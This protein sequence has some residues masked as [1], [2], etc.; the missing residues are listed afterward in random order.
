MFEKF[1]AYVGRI[2]RVNIKLIIACNIFFLALFHPL[3][4]VSYAGDMFKRAAG[5]VDLSTPDLYANLS[6]LPPDFKEGTVLPTST[7]DLSSVAN[8]EIPFY[9]ISSFQTSDLTLSKCG[10]QRVKVSP[11]HPF[12]RQLAE[13]AKN[14]DYFLPQNRGK[15]ISLR[16][17]AAHYIEGLRASLALSFDMAVPLDAV[18]R[19]SGSGSSNPFRAIRLAHVDFSGTPSKVF[20]E[21]SERWRETIAE[22]IGAEKVN[23]FLER[24]DDATVEMIHLWVPI[25]NEPANN[26]LALA[27]I[28][29]LGEDSVIPY[30][31]VRRNNSTFTALGIK[32]NSSQRW[33]YSTDMKLGD[34]Y[35]FLSRRTP[36]AS[37][38]VPIY[39]NV[40]RQS[41]EFRMLLIRNIP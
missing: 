37:I 29:S 21:F 30:T 12:F 13:N 17:A 2:M 41:I 20:S 3:V 4:S 22:R 16:R 23:H 6:F 25:H 19:I 11:T 31:A 15:E 38:D 5:R 35:V 28:R 9:D 39:G 14:P 32:H 26:T 24:L 10:F 18:Y 34:G 8:V 7:L 40:S 33:Y 1:R 36:H 27:D